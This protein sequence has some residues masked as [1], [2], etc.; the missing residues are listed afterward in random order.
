MLRKGTAL[1]LCPDV[2]RLGNR[3]GAVSLQAQL[4]LLFGAHH[5]LQLLCMFPAGLQILACL[6]ALGL[7]GLVLLLQC[8][9]LME[10]CL[11]LLVQLVVLILSLLALISPSVLLLPR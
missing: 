11:V 7:Q 1:M 9:V 10:K 6:A 5:M 3:G 8:T 4:L 2:S